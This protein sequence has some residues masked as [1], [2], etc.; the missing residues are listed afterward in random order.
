MGM[1]ISED[2]MCTPTPEGPY[3][4]QSLVFALLNWG[5]G[6]V[7]D[8]R[9]AGILKSWIDDGNRI[10]I[11]AM[12]TMIPDGRFKGMTL[13]YSM[14]EAKSSDNDSD[15]DSDDDS[16]EEVL[17]ESA[18]AEEHAALAQHYYEKGQEGNLIFNIG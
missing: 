14:F 13:A 5:N 4:G 6:T 8:Y 1:T 16:D 7:A 9:G 11:L 18:G 10:S 15:D 12:N 2:E 17:S 3:K